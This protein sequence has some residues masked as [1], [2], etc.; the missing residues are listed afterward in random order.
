[1]SPLPRFT[2][3]DEESFA[4]QELAAAWGMAVKDLEL[5]AKTRPQQ[6]E[7][8]VTHALLGGGGEALGRLSRAQISLAAMH[9]L[10]ASEEAHVDARVENVCFDASRDSDVDF[11]HSRSCGKVSDDDIGSSRCSSSSVD[12]D[13]EDLFTGGG[14]R[15]DKLSRVELAMMLLAE[16][17]ADDACCSPTRSVPRPHQCST[18][19][20]PSS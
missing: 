4:I 19:P 20:L 14:G 2:A 15:L 18:P 11:C 17:A 7:E 16:E 8:K 10:D 12:L 13:M 5:M 6:L 9:L 3:L 1:M